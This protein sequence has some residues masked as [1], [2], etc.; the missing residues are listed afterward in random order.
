MNNFGPHN[1][2]HFPEKPLAQWCTAMLALG[3]AI[4]N[5]IAVLTGILPLVFAV[6]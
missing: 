2:P 3:I 1:I 5:F 6:R 4:A